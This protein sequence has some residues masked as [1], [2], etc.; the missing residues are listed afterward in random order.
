MQKSICSAFYLILFF[1]ILDI[2][3]KLLVNHFLGKSDCIYI[4]GF[5]NIV[6]VENSGIAFGLF[7]KSFFLKRIA[8]S[9]VNIIVFIIVILMLLRRKKAPSTAIVGLSL[10]GAGALGNL[11]DRLFFGYVTDFI[12]FHV[13]MYHY[14]AFNIA[15]ACITVGIFTLI[16]HRI[17]LKRTI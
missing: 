2:V 8:L 3:S 14:P 5:L 4:F 10:L 13:G 17:I 16:V 1:F 12:D 15:D 7:G 9:S 6:H 11:K